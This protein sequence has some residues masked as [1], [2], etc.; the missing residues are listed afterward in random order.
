MK[1]FSV[2]KK[3]VYTAIGIAAAVGCVATVVGVIVGHKHRKKFDE[4]FEE[5][6]D[7]EALED[8]E[9]SSLE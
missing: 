5:G 1:R 9:A 6:F 8:E 3:T 4:F 7:N 2:S